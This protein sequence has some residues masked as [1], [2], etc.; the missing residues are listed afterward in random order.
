[1]VESEK[2]DSKTKKCQIIPKK[3]TEVKEKNSTKQT[4]RNQVQTEIK[5]SLKSR[6]LLKLSFFCF[7]SFRYCV[8]S[9]KIKHPLM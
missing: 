6:K 2:N 4:N 1:M 9:P 7:K 5:T 3:L 8:S